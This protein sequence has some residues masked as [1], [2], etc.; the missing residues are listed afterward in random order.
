MRICK[1]CGEK[2]SFKQNLK[3]ICK[4][5]GRIE[6]KKCSSV[7]ILKKENLFTWIL[8]FLY[9]YILL[10]ISDKIGGL[11]G[12]LLALV[13]GIIGVVINLNLNSSYVLK[14]NK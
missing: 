1:I 8:D 13:I 4:R 5:D 9:L 2:F 12:I 6:C 7:F 3:S 11:K 10:S 14:S